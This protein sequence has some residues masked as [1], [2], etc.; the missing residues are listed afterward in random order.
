METY[1]IEC[2]GE[3]YIKQGSDRFDGTEGIA[4]ECDDLQCKA[5]EG[6]GTIAWVDALFEKSSSI[7]I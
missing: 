3:G 1:R 6:W 7:N 4:Y 5:C 2:Q